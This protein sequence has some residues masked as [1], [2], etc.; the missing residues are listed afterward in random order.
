VTIEG[1]ILKLDADP[2]YERSDGSVQDSS[3]RIRTT[4][5]AAL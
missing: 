3:D 4:L 1:D 5:E 2:S